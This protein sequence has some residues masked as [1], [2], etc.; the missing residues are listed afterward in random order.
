MCA[1][2]SPWMNTIHHCNPYDGFP[3]VDWPSDTQ[4]WNQDS[5]IF[6]KV[7]NLL[8][9][10]KIIEVGTWKGASALQMAGI[11]KTHQIAGEI[12][13]VDTFLGSAE[14]WLNI[15]DQSLEMR[16][17]WGQPTLYFQFIANVLHAKQADV[18]IPFPTDSLTAAQFFKAKGMI[19]DAIYVD[20][21]HDYDHALADMR[22]YWDLVRPGGILFGDDYN[23]Y[24]IGVVRAV[25]DFADSLKLKINTEFQNKW[26]IQKLG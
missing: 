26:F 13:C 4:G 20:A 17:K 15:D 8:R 25:H 1:A 3:L 16:T 5:P 2:P 18:I 12:V 21:G 19:A 14:H 23:L 6:E 22:A 9:P 10:Q 7:I 24:W 11:L